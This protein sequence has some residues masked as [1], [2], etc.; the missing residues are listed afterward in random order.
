[1]NF[2]K[3]SIP[4]KINN[5]IKNN[6]IQI[7]KNNLCPK[8]YVREKIYNLFKEKI[9]L[10]YKVMLNENESYENLEN[11]SNFDVS[12]ECKSDLIFSGSDSE[13]TFKFDNK[14]I[15]NIWIL[16]TLKDKTKKNKNINLNIKTVEG[17]IIKKKITLNNYPRWTE[18]NLN[19]DLHEVD[20]VYMDN[21]S[22]ISGLKEVVFYN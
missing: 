6:Y 10:P 16:S 17:E 12:L 5:F 14:K 2:K 15:S 8:I 9:V 18:I 21:L 11:L 4:D 22:D 3:I 19:K 13:I 7:N 20:T 1:M